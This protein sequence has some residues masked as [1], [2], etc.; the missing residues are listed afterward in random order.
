MRPVLFFLG[1]A[2]SVVVFTL[3]K[4]APAQDAAAPQV[5]SQSA[6]I[7]V[8]VEL[9]TFGRMFELPACGPVVS[10]VGSRA[11]NQEC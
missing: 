6:H 11:A 9:F 1:L 8:V 2:T 5:T 4:R 10:Q 7:S 3:I